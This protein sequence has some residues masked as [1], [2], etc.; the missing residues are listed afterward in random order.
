MPDRK[1]DRTANSAGMLKLWP[2]HLMQRQLPGYEKP[3]ELLQLLILRMDTEEENLTTNYLSSGF[4]QQKNPATQWLLQCVNKTV[5]DY[6]HETGQRYKA[7]WQVQS[8]PN[9]NR[10][11]DYHDL[12]NHPHSYLSGTY[13]VQVPQTNRDLAGRA[14]RRPGAIS[15]YDPRPQANMTAVKNDPQIEAEHTVMPQAGNI[16]LWPSFLH[17]FVHPNLSDEPRISI[18][19]NIVL[20]WSDELLPQQS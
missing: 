9:I 6:L 8:W 12:H 2:T 14:D 17:H 13:Y 5:V 20:N 7:E 1:A 19:F 3:N 11:G 16:L 18:S 4:L 10:F 15:F